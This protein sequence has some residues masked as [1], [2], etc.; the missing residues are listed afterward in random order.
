MSEQAKSIMSR[1]TS[2]AQEL[3]EISKIRNARRSKIKQYP[4]V[5]VI[6]STL[7]PLDLEN[8]LQQMHAQTLRN[9]E[10]LLGL[11]DIELNA[12]HKTLI[13]KLAAKKVKVTFQ[14]FPK[15]AT[16]GQILT[17][18]CKKSTGDFISKVDD[19]DYYGPE[20]LKDLLDAA[21]ETNAD[22]VGRAMNYVYLEPLS[23][24]VR[25]FA[26]H[27]T[28]AVEL[29][30]DWVCGGTILVK[31]KIAE[32]VGWFGMGTTAV[33]RYL[34]SGVLER[35]GKIWRTFGAGYIY[36]RSFTFHT[37]ITN[38]SK[39]LNNANEQRVGI[40]SDAIFGTAK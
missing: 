17:E 4:K 9:F 36:R 31:R 37:Y 20:H 15:T 40:W 1:N 33:D 13:K 30:S 6:I 11:H 26:P 27:G 34:L 23:I 7:R 2:F 3:T 21:I 39:Y 8:I 32:A 25:R 12:R 16:L 24:T 14:N 28:Q 29:W 22:V 18:L 5:S 10:I 35:G 19:D 38:Y